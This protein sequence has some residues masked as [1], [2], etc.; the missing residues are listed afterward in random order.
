MNYV[1]AAITADWETVKNL[2]MECIMCGICAARC[3]GELAPFHIAM[4]IRRMVGKSTH[5]TPGSVAKRL[6]DI[7]DGVYESEL[8]KLKTMSKDELMV[9]YKDFQAT[10]GEAV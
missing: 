3:P 7:Q 4:L 2:S 6:K 5:K 10:K 8:A 1:S 9:L